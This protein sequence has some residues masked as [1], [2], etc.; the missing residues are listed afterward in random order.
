MA[1]IWNTVLNL[2][3]QLAEMTT[4]LLAATM[5]TPDTMNSRATMMS[6]TQLGSTP[7][8]IKRQQGCH[9]QDLVGQRVHEFAEVRHLAAANAQGSRQANRCTR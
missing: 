3:Y 4:P 2:P 6:A 9:Y 5:R 7:S 1:I 8:S